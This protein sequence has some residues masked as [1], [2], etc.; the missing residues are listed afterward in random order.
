MDKI[1][2]KKIIGSKDE[3]NGS[4]GS[5]LSFMENNEEPWGIKDCE[6]RFMYVNKATLK[7]SQLPISFS[8]EGRL[9]NECPAQWAEFT[10]ELQKQDR[11][12]EMDKKRVA[13]IQTCLWGQEHTLCEKYPLFD[14]EKKCIGTIF[15]VTKFNF[16]SLYD[17]FNKEIPPVL[18][19]SPPTNDF[20]KKEL[21]VIFYLLQSLNSK[22]IG[23]RLNLSKRTIENKLQLI[24]AKVNVNSLSSFK[25]YCKVEGFDRYI[26]EW[27][28]KKGCVFI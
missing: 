27:L 12:V 21:E 22:E 6:S 4:Y 18:V 23:E 15:H 1:N 2:H 26:P 5:L 13:M 11:E 14:N 20:T 25:E 9:D 16:I 10:P 28:I 7:F 19:M 24:Y 8:I 3:C 17:L